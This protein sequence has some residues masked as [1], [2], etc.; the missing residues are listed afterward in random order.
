M[1]YLDTG[2]FVK[3]VLWMCFIAR[4]PKLWAQLNSSAATAVRRDSLP[5]RA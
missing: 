3:A 1:T 5:Q 2:C 4:L